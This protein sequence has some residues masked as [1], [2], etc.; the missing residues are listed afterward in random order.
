MLEWIRDPNTQWVLAGTTLLGVSSGVLGCFALL[1]RRS[2]LGDALAHAALPGVCVAFLLT[3]S[4]AL[5]PLLLGALVAGLLGAWCIQV[6]G[7][8]SRLKEDSALGLVLSVFFAVGI[9]L[10]TVI[11]HSGAGNQAGLDKYVFGQ[12]ASLVGRD[13]RVM[14]ISA[15]VVC[16]LAAG[17]FK[18]LKLLCFD[19][20]FASGL[21]FRPGLLDALLMALIVF[22]VVI[23]LQAV[24]VVLMAALLIIPAASA[25]LWTDRLGRMVVFSGATGALAGA[26]GTV[27]SL[28]APGLPTGPLVVLACTSVFLVS[29]VLAPRRGLLP[30]AVRFLA[31]RRRVARENALRSLY[32]IVEESGSARR[33]VDAAA[34]AARRGR[35]GRVA[36][37]ALGRLEREGLVRRQGSGWQLT[38]RGLTAAYD[39]VR[40]HRLWEMFLMY[41]GQLGVDHVDRD[42]DYIEHYLPSEVVGELERF[43][44]LNGLEPRLLPA[45][46]VGA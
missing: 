36:R 41:E 19:P 32:E 13:V 6:I 5:G 29:L 8:S 1:R 43:L 16:V 4:R 14:A 45:P 21:G 17:L 9:L 3:E 38:E 39:V 20:G 25:R 23:G 15:V 46:G 26:L 28:G 44:R 27:V 2:L 24:G 22:A 34:V 12:A 35:P 31:L 30:R 40:N 10:L 18:E 7:S 42:A 37:R 33:V 11:Q